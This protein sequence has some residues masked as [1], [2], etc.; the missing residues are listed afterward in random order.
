MRACGVKV[1]GLCGLRA[2]LSFLDAMCNASNDRIV[3]IT[4]LEISA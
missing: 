3:L 2:E 4:H 1:I